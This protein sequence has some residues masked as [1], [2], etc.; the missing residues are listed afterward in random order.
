[1]NNSSKLKNRDNEIITNKFCQICFF[2]SKVLEGLGYN[3][4]EAELT[5]F[6]NQ[7]DIDKS[8]G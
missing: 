3:V 7:L 2:F 1:M 8:G 5:T 6:I 4:S